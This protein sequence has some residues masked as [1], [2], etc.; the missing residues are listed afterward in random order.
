MSS[1]LL[2]KKNLVTPYFYSFPIEA[3][4]KAS[5]SMLFL[6]PRLEIA[7]CFFS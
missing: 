2:M 4:G 5:M 7:V 1:T 3:L 6:I